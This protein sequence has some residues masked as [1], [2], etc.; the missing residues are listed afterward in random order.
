VTDQGFLNELGYVWQSLSDIDGG[1]DFLDAKFSLSPQSASQALRRDKTDQD[2]AQSAT[3]TS[4]SSPQ[5]SSTGSQGDG[6]VEEK[7]SSTDSE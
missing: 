2:E 1:G 5:K 6:Q 3:P 4:D 7:P